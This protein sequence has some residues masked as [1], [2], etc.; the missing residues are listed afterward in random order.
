MD[1][2]VD[3][4]VIE[5]EGEGFG[6][7]GVVDLCDA[8]GSSEGFGYF[9]EGL[10]FIVEGLALEVAPCEDIA[11]DEEEAAN[12]SAGECFGLVTTEG[13]ASDD[14]DGG[15]LECGLAERSDRGE[16]DLAGVSVVGSKRVHEVDSL[17][18]RVAPR[19]KAE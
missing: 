11:I 16:A 7:D 13:S 2:I 17:G 18:G 3:V 6:V 8:L 4:V 5:V 1:D 19:S 12:A 10:G 15:L 14:G 9:G